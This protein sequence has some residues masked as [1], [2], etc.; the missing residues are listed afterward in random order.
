[1]QKRGVHFLC[2][3]VEIQFSRNFL[4]ADAHH[5]AIVHY[6]NYTTKQAALCRTESFLTFRTGHANRK[7][8]LSTYNRQLPKFAGKSKTTINIRYA[9]VT[10]QRRGKPRDY[11]AMHKFNQLAHMNSMYLFSHFHKLNCHPIL[12]LSLTTLQ[13]GEKTSRLTCTLFDEI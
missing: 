2:K 13:R 11:Q 12:S 4:C 8:A 3:K 5:S 1:M 9:T 10:L 7:L 6:T